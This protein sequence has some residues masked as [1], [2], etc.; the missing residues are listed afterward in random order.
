VHRR[1]TNDGVSIAR[2]IEFDDPVESMGA[3]L[4]REVANQTSD[5]TGDGTTTATVRARAIVRE[6]VRT[7]EEGADPLL[8]RCGTECDCAI[9]SGFGVPSGASVVHVEQGPRSA[10]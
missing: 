6:G 8:L 2:E 9:C 10:E 1:F 3:Q 5:L 7:I 4:V